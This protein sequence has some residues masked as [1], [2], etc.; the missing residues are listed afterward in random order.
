MV[1]VMGGICIQ[2]REKGTCDG[3]F[4]DFRPDKLFKHCSHLGRYVWSSH[5]PTCLHMSCHLCKGSFSNKWR[6][7]A[8]MCPLRRRIRYGYNAAYTIPTAPSYFLQGKSIPILCLEGFSELLHA[9]VNRH[10]GGHLTQST[11]AS[12]RTSNT[13]ATFL[14][15]VNPNIDA[16]ASLGERV[17]FLIR[18]LQVGVCVLTLKTALLWLWQIA[19]TLKPKIIIGGLGG[20]KANLVQQ[21]TRF[22]SNSYIYIIHNKI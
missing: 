13:L 2:V 22:C 5:V 4:A 12:N 1:M 20:D 15:T 9:V 19:Y 16:T 8:V 7:L 14:A 17:H 10:C 11:G 3:A 18:Q 21:Q 6:V